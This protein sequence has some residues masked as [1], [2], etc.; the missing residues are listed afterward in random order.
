MCIYNV[1][2]YIRVFD[3]FGAASASRRSSRTWLGSAFLTV[4]FQQLY[5][6]ICIYIYIYTYIERERYMHTQMLYDM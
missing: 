1:I 5:M 4:L 6:C 2:V 3:S